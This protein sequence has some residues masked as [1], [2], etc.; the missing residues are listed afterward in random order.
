MT[1]GQ[2]GEPIRIS[3]AASILGVSA[4]T[5]RNWERSGKLVPQRSTGGHRYYDVQQLERFQI[6]VKQLGWTWA[7]SSQAPEL[8]EEYYCERQ[9][10]FT[11]RLEHL[12]K[13]LSQAL[14]DEVQGLVSLLTLLAGEIGDNSFTHNIG[15]WP[16]VP[17]VF[18]AYEQ[19]KRRIILADRG[20]GVRHTLQRVRPQITNDVSA[21]QIAFT[22]M[23]SGRSPEKRGNGLKVVRRTAELHPIGLIYQSGIGLVRI[24][25]GLRRMRITASDQNV[26]GVFSVIEF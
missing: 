5:L 8:S 4:Q 24:Q 13:E 7:A 3:K 11:S 9:D 21:L 25:K 20:R 2:R 26:R 17:G 16:D 12:G 10:R 18:F 22:E 15:N 19:E 1:V 23:I 6:H 14:P